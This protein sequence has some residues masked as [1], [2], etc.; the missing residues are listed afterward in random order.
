MQ[1]A[2]PKIIK[3]FSVFKNKLRISVNIEYIDDGKTMISVV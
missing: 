1:S 3:I 2:T